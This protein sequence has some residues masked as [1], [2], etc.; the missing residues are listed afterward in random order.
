M[1]DFDAFP[2]HTDLTAKLEALAESTVIDL[3][4]IGES[5][6]GREIWCATAA[7]PGGSGGP[8]DWPALLVTANVH[9]RE[10]AGSW[11]ALHLLDYLARGYGTDEKLT[12]LLDRRTVYVIPRVSPDGADF[13]LETRTRKC[14]SRFVDVDPGAVRE[15]NVV[16]PRDLTD[17]GNILTMRWPAEDGEYVVPDDEPRQTLPREQTETNGTFYHRTVEGVVANH[18]GGP[19]SEI[20]ARSDFNRNF[21]TSEWEPHDWLGHGPYPLSEPETRALAEF[22]LDR[23]NVVAAV[24]LHTGNPAIFSPEATKE[25]PSHPGDAELIRQL[26]SRAEEITGFPLLA[27]Y[28][29]ASGGDPVALGGSL[30]DWLYERLGI[31]AYIVEHGMLYNSLGIDTEDLAMDDREHARATDEALLAYHDEEPGRGVFYEWTTVEHPQLGE[32]EVGGWDWV[33][34]ANPPVEELPEIAERVTEWLLELA[35]WAPDVGIEA[36][37]EPLEGGFYRISATL[38]NRGRLPTN[39]TDRGRESTRDA[40]PLLTLSGAD[41]ENVDVVSGQERQLLDH[42]DARGGSERREWV[43][44]HSEAAEVAVEGPRGVVAE[45]QIRLD[46]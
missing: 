26:G 27:G 30:K 4:S 15:P 35:A 14:R 46:E 31:P 13:V 1:I 34:H 33:R 6:E 43:V 10:F 39:L 36:T 29:E 2:D 44:R 17:D 28:W 38:R 40:R 18:S 5:R 23:P 45:T 24:D 11:T 37:S 8:E 16:V 7:G 9:A 20:D 19:A 3:E 41:G 21:P 22:V 32:V 42:L 12:D 25:D